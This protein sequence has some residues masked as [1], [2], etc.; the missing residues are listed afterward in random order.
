MPAR[1]DQKGNGK[2]SYRSSWRTAS[3]GGTK[4]TIPITSL[5]DQ[6]RQKSCRPAVPKQGREGWTDLGQ[7]ALVG[8]WKAHFPD[9]EAVYERLLA[10]VQWLERDVVVKDR[11]LTQPRLIA[12][13]AES[14]ALAYTYSGLR[15]Q[16]APFSPL[17]Q[18]LKEEVERLAGSKFNCCLLNYY[19]HGQDR[20]AWHSDNETLFGDRPTIA[21]A[22]FGC[23]RDFVLRRNADTTDKYRFCLG[24]GDVLIMKGSTQEHWKHSVP[25]RADVEGGR[26]SLTFRTIKF[27]ENSMNDLTSAPAEMA[28]CQEE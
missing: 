12:Y 27:P 20:I 7:D 26:I 3:E 21:S 9:C 19:R 13:Q 22:S 14:S 15:L 16:P 25:K 6:A 4:E 1:P 18:G 8:Y 24:E 11:I 2:R 17:V 28:E 10:E 5:P 23:R